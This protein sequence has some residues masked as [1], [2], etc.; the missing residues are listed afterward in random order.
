MQGE[1]N[2]EAL[3]D[4]RIDHPAAALSWADPDLREAFRLKDNYATPPNRAACHEGGMDYLPIGIW[5]SWEI[6]PGFHPEPDVFLVP[7]SA[8]DAH[9]FCSFGSGVWLSRTVAGKARRVIAE[10]H[11]EFIRTGGESV[12]PSEVEAVLAELP[13]IREVAVVGIP[14][15]G[16]GEVICAAVVPEGDA[17]IEL[18]ALQS[19]CEGRLAGFKKPRR[20]EILDALPRTAATNQVQRTLIVQQILA[21]D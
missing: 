10:V 20:L 11:P 14:D 2:P 5:K 8:P 1:Q 9:G 21:N 4:V 19:H 6:P 7:V 16:W 13:G 15:P 3:R 12:A 18:E 17:R